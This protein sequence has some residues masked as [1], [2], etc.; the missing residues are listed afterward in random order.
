M[1]LVRSMTIE[2]A[3]DRLSVIDELIEADAPRATEV[4]ATLTHVDGVPFIDTIESRED[5]AAECKFCGSTTG[6]L[7]WCGLGGG[8]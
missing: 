3:S 2:Q 6:H 1:K 7:H 5:L 4:T 8:R